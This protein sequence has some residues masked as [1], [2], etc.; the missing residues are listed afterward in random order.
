MKA[1]ERDE[2]MDNTKHRASLLLVAALVAAAGAS[3]QTTSLTRER[4]AAATAALQ[5]VLRDTAGIV[6]AVPID[7]TIMDTVPRIDLRLDLLGIGRT[8]GLRPGNVREAV[9]CQNELPDSCRISVRRAVALYS[10][11]VTGRR[12]KVV[13][14]MWTRADPSLQPVGWATRQLYLRKTARGWVVVREGRA[15]VT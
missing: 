12:A 8:V 4:S 10:V 1:P 7:S 5:Y 9:T 11:M 13:L 3:A 2:R 6:E 15:S 14:E